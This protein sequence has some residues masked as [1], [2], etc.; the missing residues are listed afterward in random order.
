MSRLRLPLL[1]G[2]E[3]VDKVCRCI[4]C[5]LKDLVASLP[6]PRLNQNMKKGL[7]FGVGDVQGLPYLDPPMWC[8]ICVLPNLC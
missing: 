6:S 5:K 8:C 7:K 2:E 3:L 4:S 1:S